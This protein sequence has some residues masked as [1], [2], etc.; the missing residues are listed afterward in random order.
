MRRSEEAEEKTKEAE[1]VN[2]KLVGLDKKIE[3]IAGAVGAR[4]GLGVSETT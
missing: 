3:R 1:A 4:I 2:A